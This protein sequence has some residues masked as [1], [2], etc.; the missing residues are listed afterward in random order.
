MTPG[1]IFAEDRPSWGRLPY[2][3]L[4][5][6]FVEVRLKVGERQN[7]RKGRIAAF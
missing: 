4:S 2:T 6:Q 7:P 3:F 1:W 5:Q